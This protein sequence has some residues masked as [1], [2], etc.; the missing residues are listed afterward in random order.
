MPIGRLAAGMGLV[1]LCHICQRRCYTN[2][3]AKS[4][5]R[6][7]PLYMYPQLMKGKTAL[8]HRRKPRALANG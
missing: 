6:L 3:G 7:S 4:V 1:P 5:Q 8:Q 2:A